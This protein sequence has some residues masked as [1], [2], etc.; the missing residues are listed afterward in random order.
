VPFVRYARDKRG[1]EQIWLVH[2]PVRRGRPTRAQVLYWY[3]SPPGVRVGREPFDTALRAALEARYPDVR[4]DWDQLSAAAV[5]PPIEIEPW[6]ERRRAQRDARR[7]RPDAEDERTA[8]LVP[9][10]GVADRLIASDE[11]PPAPDELRREDGQ[12]DPAAA[13]RQR[14]SRR[15]RPRGAGAATREAIQ[16]SSESPAEAPPRDPTDRP[17]PSS[18]S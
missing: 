16:A 9:P 4:F 17:L 5:I 13:R 6:R 2:A 1:Y 11:P 3:R 12:G 18:D 15:R 10:E 8:D 7:S 14:R